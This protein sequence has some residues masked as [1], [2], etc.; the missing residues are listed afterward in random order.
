MKFLTPMM[1]ALASL[2]LVGCASLPVDRGGSATTQL[3]NTRSTVT[4]VFA[5]APNDSAMQAEAEKIVAEPIDVDSAVRLAL[6]KNSRMRALY[7]ELGIAQADVYDATRLSN[8][9]IGYMR[10]T[11]GAAAKTTWSVSQSFTE[12]LFAH[13]RSKVSRSQL[14]QTQQRVANAVLT[15][16]ADT[17]TAYYQYV[18]AD[19][20]AQMRAR[21]AML[22]AASAQYAQQLFD[23]GNISAL[24]LS[25]EQAQASETAIQQRQALTSANAA[26]GRLMTLLALPITSTTANSTNFVTTLPLPATM[27]AKL[28]EVQTWALQ[29]RLDLA[30]LRAQVDFNQSTLRQVQHWRWLGGIKVDAERERDSEVDETFSGLGAEL[31]LP[32]FNQGGGN[33]LRAQANVEIA[34]AKLAAL[35]LEIGNDTAMRY[36]AVQAAQA[37]VEEY[38]GHLIPLRERVVALSQQQQSFMLIGTFDLLNAKQQEMD[39]YQAYLE[40]VRDYWIA[41]TELQRAAGGKLP[42]GADATDTGVSVGVD[43]LVDDNTD[44][45]ET[46]SSA[47]DVNH[48]EH[49]MPNM[50]PNDGVAP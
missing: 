38:R 42:E 5:T 14:L 29:Q 20:I 37:T 24:Q 16:E 26:Q 49:D 46:T 50:K 3:L 18:G 23:A 9:S 17:R 32:L 45:D 43:A 34:H 19:L 25:R 47:S 21:A 31:E 33:A 48:A 6:L 41:Y 2:S 4:P 40:A 13:Y 11:A 22:A 7:A 27:T 39:V 35:T 15:L 28:P 30:A 8:P 10:M 36:A 12:L 1:G 44:T